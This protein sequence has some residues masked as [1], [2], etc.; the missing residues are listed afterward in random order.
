MDKKQCTQPSNPGRAV[1]KGAGRFGGAKERNIGPWTAP[2]LTA[3]RNRLFLS[4]RSDFRCARSGTAKTKEEAMIRA[5][6]ACDGKTTL[7]R[8]ARA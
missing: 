6:R 8:D 7:H 4:P 5:H 3:Q 1:R 2:W